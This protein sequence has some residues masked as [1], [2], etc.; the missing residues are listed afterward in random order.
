MYIYSDQIVALRAILLM[1]ARGYRYAV[2]HETYKDCLDNFKSFYEIEYK[3]DFCSYFRRKRRMNGLPIAWACSMPD[4]RYMND[5][6]IVVMMATHETIEPTR[7]SSFP[8]DWLE[9]QL[10]PLDQLEIGAYRIA[11]NE[12]LDKRDYVA[13]MKLTNSTL[14][15]LENRWRSL[16]SL[17][18]LPEKAW[19]AVYRYVMF[20][21][22]RQQLQQLISNYA[23]LYETSLKKPWSGPDPENLPIIGSFHV[24]ANDDYVTT[25]S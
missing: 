21:G 19:S 6:Q 11:T 22:V 7:R 16:E 18:Q 20:R 4:V 17:E 2:V 3:T 9:K 12:N 5:D 1:W 10:R 15:E 24:V 14:D 13:T 25:L 23:K 8:E